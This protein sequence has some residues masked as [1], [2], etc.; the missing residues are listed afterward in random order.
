MSEH[1]RLARDNPYLRWSAALAAV[2]AF[3]LIPF[4]LLEDTVVA[5]TLAAMDALRAHPLLAG[6]AI[7]ALLAGDV[8][9]P[10]PSSLVGTLA[11]AVLG[12]WGGVAAVWLGMTAGCL[13]GYWLGR[14]AGRV[15]MRRIVGEG[16]L[17]R[18]RAKLAGAGGIAVVLTRGVPVLA[19]TM[20]L[21]AGAARMP[22]GP[23]LVLSSATNLAVALA[24]S[25][26]GALALSSGSFFLFFFGL[27]AL[28]GAGWLLWTKLGK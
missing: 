13:L 19:E 4:A 16:E 21:G 27:A 10:I 11:G 23:F 8:V 3:V 17:E 15:A 6:G 7:A 1:C 18:A 2:F 28:P 22:L 24:Y 26:I 9:L 5:A 14:S 20:V 25:A 12:F